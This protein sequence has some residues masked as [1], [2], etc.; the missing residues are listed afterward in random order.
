[1]QQEEYRATS[2]NRVEAGNAPRMKVKLLSSFG[3]VKTYMVV[4]SKEDEVLSGLT[5]FAL[6]QDAKSAHFQGMGSA[7]SLELG[8]F[9]FER[10]MYQVIPVGIAEVTSLMGNITWSA[11]KPIVHAHATASLKGGSVTGGHFLKMIVRPT[12][13]VIVTVEPTYLYKTY[14]EEFQAEMIDVEID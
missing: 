14:N 7:F 2:S 6:K 5:E 1:M 11:G 12:L 10:L 4:F 9:D 13:E 8:W 3:R